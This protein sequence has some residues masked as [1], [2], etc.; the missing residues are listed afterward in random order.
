MAVI[1]D[2]IDAHVGGRAAVAVA[3]LLVDQTRPQTGGQVISITHS[4]SVAAV[5][6]KH[7]V[8]QKASGNT[9][10][11]TSTNPIIVSLVD[12]TLR[13]QELGRMCGGDLAQDEAEAFAAALLRDGESQRKLSNVN[14]D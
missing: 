1:Y 9:S 5:A 11:E 8:I 7:V 6:D 13:E 4:P 14:G 3:K 12:G 2:E 10:A